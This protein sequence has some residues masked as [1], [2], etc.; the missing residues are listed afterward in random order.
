MI[1]AAHYFPQ[2]HSLLVMLRLRT[3]RGAQD[4][5]SQ[6]VRVFVCLDPS[7]HGELTFSSVAWANASPMVMMRLRARV[8]PSLHFLS[9]LSPLE[10]LL[11]PSD[12]VRR[13]EWLLFPL[14]AFYLLLPFPRILHLVRSAAPG[15]SY[16][17]R[18]WQLFFLSLPPPSCAVSG[19]CGVLTSLPNRRPASQLPLV[20]FHSR[21]SDRELIQ[22]SRTRRC[23]GSLR[24]IL[25]DLCATFPSDDLRRIRDI[26]RLRNLLCW[27]RTSGRARRLSPHPPFR[28]F[29]LSTAPLCWS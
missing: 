5:R 13:T 21:D 3:C 10:D 27:F 22:V 2:V 9:C 25:P 17:R 7:H 8:A 4:V 11:P 24:R 26:Y 29:L 28:F 1:G 20:V 18:L 15:N 23:R 14:M 19:S 12:G 6:I 16:R